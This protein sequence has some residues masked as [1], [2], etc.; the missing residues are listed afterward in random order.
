MCRLLFRG[1]SAAAVVVLAG[2]CATASGVRGHFDDQVITAAQIDSSGAQTA[3][4]AVRKLLPQLN[5]DGGSIIHR[6]QS[7]IVL[8]D[9]IAVILDGAR[10][11]DYHAIA[12]IPANTIDT[13]RFISG[14]RG[15]T[16]Y[17]LNSGDGVLVIVTKRGN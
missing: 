2:G 7:S 9:A 11:A 8:V 14:I 12:D 4:D 16:L 15:T 3:W 13:M 17:G 5:V 10:L 6:G 1:L